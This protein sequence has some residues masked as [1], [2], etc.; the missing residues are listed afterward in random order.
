MVISDGTWTN[1]IYGVVYGVCTNTEMHTELSENKKSDYQEHGQCQV[2]VASLV[3]T[4]Q[5]IKHI[6]HG[7]LS[8]LRKTRSQRETGAYI[9]F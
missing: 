3:L 7:F 4:H 6:W 2:T 5:N 1:C 8:A 9:R